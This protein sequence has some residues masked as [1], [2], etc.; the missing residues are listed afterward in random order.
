MEL[1]FLQILGAF[2]VVGKHVIFL[3]VKHVQEGSRANDAL[4]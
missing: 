2:E 3:I 4:C 1:Q